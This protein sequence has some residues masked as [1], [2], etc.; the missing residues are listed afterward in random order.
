MANAFIVELRKK[1]SNFTG[2][3]KLHFIKTHWNALEGIPSDV[4]NITSLLS[5]KAPSSH[6]HDD[7]YFTKN[8]ITN[9]FV[10][11]SGKQDIDY[12]RFPNGVTAKNILGTQ[13]TAGWFKV[14]TITISAFYKN[15]PFVFVISQRA[16][17]A[18]III[19]FASTN[20][21]DPALTRFEAYNTTTDAFNAKL[22]KSATS[23]WELWV[24]KSEPYDT[25]DVLQYLRP[26]YNGTGITVT[27]EN[28]QQSTEPDGVAVTKFY[29]VTKEIVSLDQNN[30][31]LV[32]I[33]ATDNKVKTS[34]ISQL[35]GRYMRFMS[36]GRLEGPSYNIDNMN[37][38]A[39]AGFW[40]VKCQSGVQGTFPSGISFDAVLLVYPW[41]SD[42]YA[43][44]EITETASSGY[45]R[46]WVRKCNNGT[47]DPWV[48]IYSSDSKPSLADLPDDSTHRLVT[49]AEKS[50]WNGKQ[51]ALTTINQI[52]RFNHQG[53]ATSTNY[54]KLAVFP[55][56]NTGNYSSVIIRGR[57]GGWTNDNMAYFEMIL[58]NRSGAVDGNTIGASIYGIG[59][60]GNAQSLASVVVYKQADKSAIAYLKLNGY[61]AYDI[62]VETY[63]ATIDYAATSVAPTGTL[64][65]ESVNEK[66]ITVQDGALRVYGSN[67]DKINL[68]GSNNPYIRFH[69]GTTQR[70]YIQYASALNRFR[71]ENQEAQTVLDIGTDLIFKKDGVEKNVL[72]DNEIDITGLTVNLN[73]QYLVSDY[74]TTEARRAAPV[75]LVC[76]SA[77]G[78]ANISNAV[79]TLGTFKVERKIVRYT[80]ATDYTIS[81]IYT[82]APYENSNAG[83]Y[84]RFGHLNGA[85]LTWTSWEKLAL[86]SELNAKQDILLRPVSSHWWESR[87][88]MIGNDGVME[89]GK[90]ID[91][92]ITN[93][94]TTDYDQRLEADATGLKLG[95]KYLVTAPT[96]GKKYLVKDGGLVEFVGGSGNYSET[97]ITTLTNNS[98]INL[99]S[100]SGYNR[101]KLEL[102]VYS[103]D[104]SSSTPYKY[105]VEELYPSNFVRKS[106]EIKQWTSSPVPG[107]TY[108]LDEESVFIT[109]SANFLSYLNE[110]YPAAS[111]NV[112]D[113]ARGRKDS[114]SSYYYA[115]VTSS[116]S[117]KDAQIDFHDSGKFATISAT[118]AKFTAPTTSGVTYRLKI[119]GINF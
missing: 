10:A 50:T 45:T 23:T 82:Y 99:S 98:N 78:G 108:V 19:E 55:I 26:E 35:D 39:H 79:N 4:I 49:D 112:G 65:W 22:Y 90:Y 1:S 91:F 109:S 27:W 102:Y 117:Y 74:F 2:V 28:T 69:E 71:L 63:Q 81:D 18:T 12:K 77:G 8:E 11:L 47:W 107:T 93:G 75:I 87:T 70:A 76:R 30:D 85:T 96:D 116:T 67:D 101:I 6:T 24:H 68:Y 15:S 61:Y 7:R 58:T 37:D 111:Y 118:Q 103:N 52:P 29:G 20:N 9:N 41:N 62:E 57:L 51:N 54:H 113:W 53:N 32:I 33:D 83:I 14:A 80:S 13:G 17:H 100:F 38:P 36:R 40:N 119:I 60:I 48:Q 72:L 25:L 92:H 88:P 84:I 31:K 46:R 115:R 114:A 110:Y 44:Q 94:G 56:D 104:S 59:K 34:Q 105:K 89:I 21:L 86:T 42:N 5:G 66:T 73:T 16:R 106:A 43:M 64:I 97:T 3:E 95:G